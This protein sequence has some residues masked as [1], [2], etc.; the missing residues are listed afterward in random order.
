[1]VEQPVHHKS[2]ALQRVLY[3]DCCSCK[4]CVLESVELQCELGSKTRSKTKIKNALT[5][6]SAVNSDRICMVGVQG[7]VCIEQHN[8]WLCSSERLN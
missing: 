2:S 5:V 4:N 6:D 8:F 1:M 3:Y 7:S